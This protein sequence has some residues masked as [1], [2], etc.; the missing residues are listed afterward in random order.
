M[1]TFTV[2]SHADIGAW[3]WVSDIV[4]IV[5]VVIHRF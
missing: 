2:Y 5:H 1:F 3:T 4:S